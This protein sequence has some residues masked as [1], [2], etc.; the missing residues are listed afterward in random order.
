MW[1][2]SRKLRRP[3]YTS[4]RIHRSAHP[5]TPQLRRHVRWGANARILERAPCL[6]A[7]TTDPQCSATAAT[8]DSR[9]RG[10]SSISRNGVCSCRASCSSIS[11]SRY[12]RLTSGC[13]HTA[14]S[15]RT[16][17]VLIPGRSAVCK[18]DCGTR[19]AFHTAN[20]GEYNCPC[21]LTTARHEKAV[22]ALMH[23]FHSWRLCSQPSAVWCRDNASMSQP[24]SHP[25]KPHRTQDPISTTWLLM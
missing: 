11:C 16:Q 21:Q 1:G 25:V 6:Q 24:C 18:P 13:S 7:S 17:G 2:R 23:P 14:V 22:A 8:E 3:L 4:I 10:Q 9:S 12:N 19:T 20:L 5:Y 15:C